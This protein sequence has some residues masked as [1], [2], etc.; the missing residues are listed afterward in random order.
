MGRRAVDLE[1]PNNRVSGQR[2]LRTSPSSLGDRS[3]N[4]FGRHISKE[5][6]WSCS[7][8][9]L[10]CWRF[11]NASETNTCSEPFTNCQQLALPDGRKC[12]ATLGTSTPPQRQRCNVRPLNRQTAPVQ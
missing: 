10:D 3:S 12:S 7:T 8:G 11:V 6:R 4:S 2:K 9:G 1:G 5:T